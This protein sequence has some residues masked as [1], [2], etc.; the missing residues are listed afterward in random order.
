M[1]GATEASLGIFKEEVKFQF[2]HPVWGATATH[3]QWLQPIPLQF[4]HPVWGATTYGTASTVPRVF[5]FTHPVWGATHNDAYRTDFDI[6]SIHAPRVGCDTADL[7]EVGFS[8]SV[9]IHAPRVGCDQDQNTPTKVSPSFNSRT[10]CGVRPRVPTYAGISEVF[11]FTHPVWGATF[12][13]LVQLG[14][15]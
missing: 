11:Q 14:T 1:W 15:L 4:T 7:A 6:V 2:T 13:H 12:Y 10:P 8:F 5:Q 3:R 9:S